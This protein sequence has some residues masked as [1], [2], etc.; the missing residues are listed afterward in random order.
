[1]VFGNSMLLSVRVPAGGTK[2]NTARAPS[3]RSRDEK[4][5]KILPAPPNG[6]CPTEAHLRDFRNTALKT[7]TMQQLLRLCCSVGK[8]VMTFEDLQ[9]FFIP[10]DPKHSGFVTEDVF[11]MLLSDV[12]E[13]F[14]PDEMDDIIEE[15][16]AIGD[17]QIVAS[18]GVNYERFLDIVMQG[19][20]E[21]GPA[22]T[23]GAAHPAG[24]PGYDPGEAADADDV[25]T[26][27][28]ALHHAAG[29]EQH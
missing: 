25:P 13:G 8:P 15:C 16:K 1:M 22:A 18:R 12:G 27:F 17:K 26:A 14:L 5:P 3:N 23:A 2:T 6:L 29:S 21:G 11:R 20:G 24:D 9:S 19:P 28:R 7:C 10:Y 4:S